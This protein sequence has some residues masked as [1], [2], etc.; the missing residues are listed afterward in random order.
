[1]NNPHT[2][3]N[4]ALTLSKFAKTLGA[5]TCITVSMNVQAAVVTVSNL[6]SNDGSSYVVPNDLNTYDVYQNI[7]SGSGIGTVAGNAGEELILLGAHETSL[8]SSDSAVNGCGSPGEPAC[9]D[10]L[11]VN[12]TNLNPNAQTDGVSLL[13]TASQSVTWDLVYDVNAGIDLRSIFIFGSS[14]NGQSLKIN[15]TDVVIADSIQAEASPLNIAV[16]PNRICAFAHPV[17]ESG[18]STDDLLG[19]GGFPFSFLSLETALE[20]TNFNG[21]E[22]VDQFDVVISS[23]VTAVPVPAALVL[24]SSALAGLIGVRIK[25]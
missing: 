18:C 10:V 8:H 2:L 23:S 6:W 16:S 24:F 3:R 17:P 20:V 12:L 5:I 1:M 13:L 19:Y 9:N 14:F 21:S 15:G 4:G 11:R 7:Q 25:K 22:Y